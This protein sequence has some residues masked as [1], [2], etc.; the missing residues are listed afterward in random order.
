MTD[1]RSTDSYEHLN[2]SDNDVYDAR[3]N[4]RRGEGWEPQTGGKE[5]V[6]K[7]KPRVVK[8]KKKERSKTTN[9]SSDWED[10]SGGSQDD[11]YSQERALGD[12]QKK[13]R[14]EKEKKGKK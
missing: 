7:E 3:E 10:G 2:S 11:L 1:R 12:I 8:K 4:I 9:L 14:K 5:N 6:P 13:Q